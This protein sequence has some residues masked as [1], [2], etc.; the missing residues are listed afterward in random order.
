MAALNVVCRSWIKLT[1]MGYAAGLKVICQN[2]WKLKCE[3]FSKGV[4]ASNS[5]NRIV[6][7]RA[8]A[9]NLAFLIFCWDLSDV[10]LHLKVV[11]V[12]DLRRD[13]LFVSLLFVLDL[14]T[15]SFMYWY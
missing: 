12:E 15:L 9:Q 7:S 2:S 1:N 4:L 14:G 6:S 10:Q 3:V 5:G 11:Y 8:W 13:A